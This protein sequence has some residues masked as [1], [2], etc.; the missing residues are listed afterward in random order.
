MASVDQRSFH[1][2]RQEDVR[3]SKALSW[4][5]RHGAEKEGVRLTPDG[6]ANLKDVLGHRTFAGKCTVADV[7][8]IVANDSKG[9]YTLRRVGDCG[10]SSDED[11]AQVLEIKAN[12]G[13]SI[14][15]RK[16]EAMVSCRKKC[17]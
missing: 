11:D 13:H 3:L 8:R 6:F 14:Q 1:G 10:G 9:R 12:Q 16:S 2:T 17:F 4:L 15:V 5:L 7:K